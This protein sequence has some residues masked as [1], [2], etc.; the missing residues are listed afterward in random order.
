MRVS[1]KRYMFD[2]KGVLEKKGCNNRDLLVVLCMDGTHNHTH[3][4]IYDNMKVE[5]NDQSK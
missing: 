3:T 5:E 1:E 2:Q 4:N